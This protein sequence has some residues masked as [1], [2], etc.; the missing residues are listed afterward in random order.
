[1]LALRNPVPDARHVS[2]PFFHF[3]TDR[4]LMKNRALYSITEAREL[5]G[6][7][8]RNTIYSLLHTGQLTSVVIGSRRFISQEAITQ[9]TDARP[10]VARSSSTTS[11]FRCPPPR[12]QTKS[13]PPLGNSRSRSSP[14]STGTQW[15]STYV[16]LSF[17]WSECRSEASEAT[18]RAATPHNTVTAAGATGSTLCRAIESDRPPAARESLGRFGRVPGA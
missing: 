15:C 9:G 11:F 4:C 13:W 1:M 3:P 14:S 6:G 8:S 5:L 16:E 18:S 2:V 17:M 12:P 10:P 7:M